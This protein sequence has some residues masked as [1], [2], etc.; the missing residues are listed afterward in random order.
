[1]SRDNLL[2]TEL[3][4]VL[5]GMMG[6]GKTTVGQAIAQLA[7]MPFADTDIM[8]EDRLKMAIP[9]IFEQYG[10]SYFR[11]RETEAADTAS[12]YRGTVIATGGGMVINPKN[13][14]LLGGSGFVVYLR[15]ELP[16]I[17]ERTAGDEN[18]PLAARLEE[19]LAVREPL[20]T[21]YSN[22]IID[23]GE[24]DANQLAEMILYE[25]RSNKRA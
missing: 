11:Q 15:L 19:L 13:M 2:N 4:I 21:R 12:R 20:Y 22:L 7:S 10:E 1:M 24:S 6:C 5:I 3:N 23:T 18:R 9:H 14:V 8:I 17:V 25:Y 16:K